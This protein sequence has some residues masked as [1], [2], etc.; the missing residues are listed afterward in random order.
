MTTFLRL[1]DQALVGRRVLIRADLNVPVDA[2]GRISDDTR[3]VASLAAMR[4]ALDG[5]RGR[6]RLPVC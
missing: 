1:E 5:G 6:R 2:E 3:I 4:L